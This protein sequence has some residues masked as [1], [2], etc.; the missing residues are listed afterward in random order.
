MIRNLHRVTDTTSH[1]APRGTLRRI[2]SEWA[3]AEGED[4]TNCDYDRI[5]A[6]ALGRVKRWP[7]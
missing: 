6:T 1:P 2:V 7:A 5:I 3:H 4:L